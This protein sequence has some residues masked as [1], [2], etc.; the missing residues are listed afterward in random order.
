MLLLPGMTLND[1]EFPELG[2]PTLAPRY[3]TLVEPHEDDEMAR[4]LGMDEYVRAL[5]AWLD[6]RPQWHAARHRVVLAHSFGAMLALDWLARRPKPRVD[7]LV[8]IS[9]SPGPLFERLRFRLSRS[10]WRVPVSPLMP[11]WNTRFL[12]RTVKRLL[13]RSSRVEPEDF[14]LLSEPSEAA[15]DRLGWRGTDWKQIRAM[16]FALDGF[17]V[18]ERLHLI[19]ASTIVLHGERDRLFDVGDPQYIAA[20]VP[21]AELRLFPEASHTLPLTHP[22]AVLDAVSWCCDHVHER[23]SSVETKA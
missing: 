9:V 18:R 19:Q 11:L 2:L 20:N 3:R 4:A 15:V 5:Q 21:G 14:Q 17:D 16:R 6:A 1:S 8:A 23:E 10:G 22:E 12:T 7:G 13:G